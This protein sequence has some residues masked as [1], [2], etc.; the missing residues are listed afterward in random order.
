MVTLVPTGP[1]TG[2]KLLMA[3][4]GTTVKLPALVA[5]PKGV[6]TEIFPVVAPAGTGAVIWVLE[7]TVNVVLVPLNVTFVVLDRLEPATVTLVP[8]GPDVGV[9]LLMV[10][11]GGGGTAEAGKTKRLMLWAG[12]VALKLLPLTAIS[13]SFEMVFA[14]VNCQTLATPEFVKLARFAVVVALA[15]NCLLITRIVSAPSDE[16]RAAYADTLSG[17]GTM[18]VTL[19]S[20]KPDLAPS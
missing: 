9:K 16:R 8:I 17:L 18:A 4:D 7:T 13:D 5:R 10:G 15:P 14:E 19:V 20:P 6:L 3:G 11:T 1:E 12:T 2:L